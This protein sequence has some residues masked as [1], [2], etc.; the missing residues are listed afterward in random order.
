MVN[1]KISVTVRESYSHWGLIE[2]SESRNFGTLTIVCSYDGDPQHHYFETAEEVM[3]LVLVV[4][5]KR[6]M[7]AIMGK[8]ETNEITSRA[9]FPELEGALPPEDAFTKGNLIAM[10]PTSGTKH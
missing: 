8:H 1:D 4:Y 10:E 9:W 5:E 6:G 2:T 3:P 7:L